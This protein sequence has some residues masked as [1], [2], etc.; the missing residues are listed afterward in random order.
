MH[1][2]IYA[3]DASIKIENGSGFFGSNIGRTLSFAE[4]GGLHYDETLGEDAPQTGAPE[5][6]Y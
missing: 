3:P 4:G 5:L 2:V 1:A 6:V